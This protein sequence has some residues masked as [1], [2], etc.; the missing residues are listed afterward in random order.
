MRRSAAIALSV[1]ICALLASATLGRQFDGATPGD[2]RLGEAP[3]ADVLRLHGLGDAQFVHRA[4]SLRLQH[5]GNLGGRIVPFAAIDYARV[6]GWFRAL[7]DLDGRADVVPTMAAFLYSGS[8]EAAD[9]RHL[10]DYLARRARAAPARD[11]RWMT[12]AIY[13]ARYRLDANETALRLANEMADFE[14]DAVPDWA[15]HLRILVL[16]DVGRVEAA[17]ALVNRLLETE[18]GIEPRERRWLK[19]YLDRELQ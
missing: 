5:L 6:T 18:T 12:H 9:I 19:Y 1:A 10:V 8:P 13:L 17:R 11:W 2:A 7:D 4:H 3:D 16:R 15:R 14:T